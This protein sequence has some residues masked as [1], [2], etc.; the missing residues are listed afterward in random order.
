MPKA[1]DRQT[2]PA[3]AKILHATEGCDNMWWL[4]I[5][6]IAKQ[7]RNKRSTQTVIHMH[8]AKHTLIAC[9]FVNLVSQKTRRKA[10]H[11]TCCCQQLNS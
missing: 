1:K 7:I 2:S 4:C 5:W 9:A 11:A 8:V 3:F 6:V 10:L